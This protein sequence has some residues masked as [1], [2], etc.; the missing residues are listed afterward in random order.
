MASTFKKIFTLV[1]PYGRFSARVASNLNINHIW[2][3][4]I[5]TEGLS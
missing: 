1:N 4:H 2:G 5:E 3:K